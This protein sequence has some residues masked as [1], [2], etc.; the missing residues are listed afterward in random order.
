MK[1]LAV[2]DI[3]RLSDV[4]AELV[5]SVSDELGINMAI[6]FLDTADDQTTTA[7]RLVLLIDV[8]L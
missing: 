1:A 2:K 3:V 6:A 7:E 5:K 8:V 4:K